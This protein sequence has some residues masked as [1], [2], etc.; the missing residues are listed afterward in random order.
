MFQ[1]KKIAWAFALLGA[2]AVLS[3]PAAAADEDD[4]VATVTVTGSLIPQSQIETAV[5]V[6][7]ISA[8]DMQVRGFTS[9]ADA[10]Q[11]AAFST[12]SVQG[13]QFVNGFTPGVKT[14]SLFGLSPSYVKYLID[15]RPMVDYPALYNGTD[16]ITSISGIPL[17]LV[18]HIDILPGGQSSIYGSDA[19]AGVVNI[20]MRKE[21]DGGVVDASYQTFQDGGG[22]DRRVTAANSF[23]LGAV[24]LLAGL[25]L[26]KIDPIWG[27]QRDLTKQYFTQG[28]SEQVAERDF[29]VLGNGIV[30]PLQYFFLDPNNC[31]N[32]RGEFN[33]T[34]RRQTRADRGDYCGTRSAGFYTVS[35]GAEQINGYLRGTMDVNEGLTLYSDILASREDV[36]FS[37]GTRYYSTDIDFGLVYDPNIDEFMTLQHI[38]SPE[39]A[40]GLHNHMDEANTRAYSAT[41]GGMGPIMG[42]SWTYDVGF[43]YSANKLT[44][45][46]DLLLTDAVENFFA[47]ILGANLGNDPY[48]DF[49]PA[50]APDYEAFYTPITPEDYASFNGVTTSK[51]DSSD[52]MLRAQITQ[53]TLFSLPGGD[54]GLA[55]VGEYGRQW[56]KYEPDPRFLN[57][58]TYAYTATAGR[59]ERT[60]YA[61]TSELRLPIWQPLTFTASG[62]YDNYRVAGENVDKATYMAGLELR[63][64]PSLL[65]RGRYG[66]AFKAPTLSDEFQGLSGFYQLV[67]DY[68]QCGLAG[69]SF[70]DA[71]SCPYYNYYFGE[72]S[73]NPALKPINAKVWNVGVVFAPLSKLSIEANLLHWNID[74]EVAQQDSDQLLRDEASCRNGTLDPTS[75]TCVAA[76]SQVTR[77]SGDFLVSFI[78]PKINVANEELTAL[79]LHATYGQDIGRFGSLN[80]KADYSDTLKHKYQQF[81]GDEVLNLLTNPYWSTEFKTV[82][83]A[84]I[85]WNIAR[86]STTL[87]GIR[88]GSAPN[89]LAS[90][91]PEGYATPGAGKLKAWTLANLNVGYRLTDQINLSATVNNLFD[92]MPPED[93]SYPG[94]EA[95]PY[96][97][98]NYNIYGRSFMMEAGY[99]FGK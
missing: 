80:F 79:T 75:P 87:Y 53:P 99:N 82:V 66:T 39:E 40:G 14:L 35:N 64:L 51:S 29:L 72:T 95:Q 58:Q 77:D 60:R 9:V 27:Y 52:S 44:E 74:D 3:W 93:R 23:E 62:R 7:V 91:N 6:T 37:P 36:E 96:N 97:I 86:L 31:A 25:E 88:R 71:T 16:I 69:Y 43:T 49:Y 28:T 32:V 47:P 4:D 20:I 61:V 73:G 94:T 8:E 19:I 85:T 50:F 1:I 89:Y 38:F 42:S 18:D 33:N 48:F 55:V 10:V 63:P 65:L 76:L 67:P 12:G 70:A 54:A 98:F 26:G 90:L 5:P 84:S 22:R 68:Y 78:T 2:C 83:N 15:G 59:G 21:L 11:Q 56:W 92:E 30:Q 45:H 81:T 57:G 24:H 13:Q 17:E 34:V 46:T 41:L